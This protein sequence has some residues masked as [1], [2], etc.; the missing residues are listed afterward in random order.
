MA[1]ACIDDGAEVILVGCGYYGPILRTAG[2]TEIPGTG[3]PVVDCSAV[4]LKQAECMADLALTTG[5]VKSERCYFRP[6]PRDALDTVRQ[7]LGIA[8]SGSRRKEA[9]A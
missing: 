4:A 1:R 6:P 5:L 2:Y 3:V 8:G 9:G 7:S